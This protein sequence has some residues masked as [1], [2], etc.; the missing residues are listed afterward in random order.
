MW[1]TRKNLDLGK[2]K[3]NLSSCPVCEV[4]KNRNP[5]CFTHHCILRAYHSISYEFCPIN[6]NSIKGLAINL[7]RDCGQ[8]LPLS[9]G[10]K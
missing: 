9:E 6:T 4:Q 10:G 8:S 1:D 5:I 3:P 2:K 7:L